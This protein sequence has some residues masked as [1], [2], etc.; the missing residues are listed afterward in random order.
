MTS[1]GKLNT[2]VIHGYKP[3]SLS[4]VD[5]WRHGSPLM[6]GLPPEVRNWR[7]RNL[8]SLLPSW[9]KVKLAVTAGHLLGVMTAYG[10]LSIVVIRGDTG[11]RINYGLASFKLVTNTG[12]AFIVDAFQNLVELENMRFHGIG[13]GVGGE[14]AADAALGTEL[15]TQ[16]NPDNTRATG[17]ITE[18]AANIFRTVGTNTLDSGTPAVTEHG[19]LSSATVGAGVLL[20]RSVFAA[21]N[22][23]GA[24]A[25][26]LQTTYDLT[27]TAGG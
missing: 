15:T 27:L 9:V 13:T 26:A 8:P 25:D 1:R 12:V 22:L 20:D 24:N 11:E 18:S 10:A 16:Y 17:S 2:K 14:L 19:V 7:W 21:I 6:T 5:L 23:V 4:L 3:G